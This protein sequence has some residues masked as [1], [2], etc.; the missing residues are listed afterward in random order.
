MSIQNVTPHETVTPE[1]S[2]ASRL[3][4]RRS[5][6][7]V[8]AADA[9]V[10]LVVLTVGAGF[11]AAVVA[12][13]T[14][15]IA[16][17]AAIGLHRPRLTLSALDDAGPLVAGVL[18]A[19]VVSTVAF[20]RSFDGDSALVAVA[21]A[22]AVVAGRAMT[23]WVVRG[24]RRRRLVAHR[25]LVVG[26]GFT[27]LE[28]T[29]LLLDHPE[30]GL[31]PVGYFDP[32]PVPGIDH[33]IPVLRESSSIAEAI[34]DAEA[35]VVIVAFGSVSERELV[36]V[37]R[38]CDRVRAEIFV[39]PRLYEMFHPGRSR[40]IDSIWGIPLVRLRRAS[41]RS[42]AWMLKRA[43]DLVVATA[44]GVVLLPVVAVVAVAARL[45]LG[46]GII[47][48]QE[49]V[50]IDG[51]R[52]EILKFRTMRSVDE[53]DPTTE[54]STDGAH[55]TRTGAFLRRFSLDEI[56]QLWNVLRGDMS[57]VGPRPERP[58]FVGAFTDRYPAYTHR[59]RVPAGMTGLAQV[60]GLRGDTSIECRARFDNAYIDGWSVWTD[61]KI[62]ALT[63]AS[64]LR[65]GSSR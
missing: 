64:V 25:T 13:T 29:E 32:A 7:Y 11:D 34:V 35:D 37:L 46:P 49:R 17:F 47:F 57:L 58:H 41:H 6:R 31:E 50:G 33:P 54:W 61:I 55:L 65:G 18:S 21:A 30:Y 52:F 40:D 16:V 10:L 60:M 28:L 4:H 42:P 62:L 51:R 39:I 36:G 20:G 14:G 3:F 38:A 5:S 43:F 27:G 24:A 56:P 23:Y 63:L 2:R 19:F 45:S 1:G 15:A 12:T 53:Y 26:A 22:L 44:A 8:L 48:R 9:V 59:H